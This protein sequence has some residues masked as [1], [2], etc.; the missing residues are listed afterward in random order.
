M[1]EE[2]KNKRYEISKEDLKKLGIEGEIIDVYAIE[3]KKSKAC[4]PDGYSTRCRSS[5]SDYQKIAI[6]IR[7]RNILGQ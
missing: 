1:V 7:K 4:I 2:I 5:E 3:P 6:T